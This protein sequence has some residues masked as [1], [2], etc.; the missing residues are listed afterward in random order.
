[1]CCHRYVDAP[2]KVVSTP[3]SPQPAGGVSREASGSGPSADIAE[4]LHAHHIAEGIVVD[5]YISDSEEEDMGLGML[6]D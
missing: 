2:K 6:A 1:V 5:E 4:S 3:S